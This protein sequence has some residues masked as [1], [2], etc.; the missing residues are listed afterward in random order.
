MAHFALSNCKI[1]LGTFDLTGDMNKVSI[2]RSQADLDDTTWPATFK[3][4]IIG[5]SDGQIGMAGLVNLADDGQDEILSGNMSLSN[6]PVMISLAGAADFDRCKFGK[7]QQGQYKTGGN[8][9]QRAEWSADGRISS[10][11]LTDGNVMAVG[12]KTGTFN[13]TWRDLGAVLDTQKL[14]AQIHATAKSSFTSA[15]FKVQSAD[16]NIGTN[17]TDRITFTTITG[18]TSEFKVL[19]G[20]ITQTFFRVMC[21]A[22]T[23]TSLAITAGVG[24][25]GF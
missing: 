21:S 10:N 13:G 3:A 4:R 25:A 22:F 7:I 16:D 24:I 6:I 14:Y 17:A 23:G 19:A 1:L 9:G 20:P 18:L 15:V 2:A 5:L 11:V 12:T 8:V